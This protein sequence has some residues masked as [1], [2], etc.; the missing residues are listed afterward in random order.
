MPPRLSPASPICGPPSTDAGSHAH[1]Q[2]DERQSTASPSTDAGRYD[3]DTV[4]LA[5]EEADGLDAVELDT[6]SECPAA[7]DEPASEATECG[8]AVGN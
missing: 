5:A 3:A 2:G 1:D 6:T 8:T 7:V 4:E